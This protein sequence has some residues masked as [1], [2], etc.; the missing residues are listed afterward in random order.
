[1]FMNEQVNQEDNEIA[2]FSDNRTQVKHYSK[3]LYSLL[4][5]TLLTP[6]FEEF[7]KSKKLLNHDLIDSLYLFNV[8]LNQALDS[9]L[10]SFTSNKNYLVSISFF[11]FNF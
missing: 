6:I 10:I 5:L 9:L 7:K 1:M 2:S 3:S 8:S 11:K 4:S